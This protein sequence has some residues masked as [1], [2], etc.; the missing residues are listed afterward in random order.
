M[1]CRFSRIISRKCSSELATSRTIDI[2]FLSRQT[3]SLLGIAAIA[4]DG[5]CL[6]K[7][8]NGNCRQ[9]EEILKARKLVTRDA[10]R[11]GVGET[12]DRAVARCA[13]EAGEFAAGGIGGVIAHVDLRLALLKL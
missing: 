4:L 5:Q 12:I 3:H 10:D 8:R 7:V 13:G 2:G 11:D 6:L 1:L 9:T